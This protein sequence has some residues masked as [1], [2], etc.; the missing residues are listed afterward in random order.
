MLAFLPLIL[1]S[2]LGPL[3]MAAGATLYYLPYY[4]GKMY[5]RRKETR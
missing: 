1:G 3:G 4:A 2:W 5:G